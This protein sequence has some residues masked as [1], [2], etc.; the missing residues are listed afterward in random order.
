[1][2]GDW[3]KVEHATTRKAEVMKMARMLG[4]NRREMVGTLVDFFVWCDAN[5]VDG[6]VDGVVDADVD[7]VMMCP[8]LSAV[9]KEVGWLSFDADPPKMRM[10]NWDRHNGETAKKRALKNRAQSKWRAN[11]D[12]AQSTK[13]STRE[14]K[15]REDIKSKSIARKKP[16]LPLPPD[17]AISE[18]VKTWAAEKGFGLLDRHFEAFIGKVRAKGYTYVDWDEALMNCIRED[19]GKVN[20]RPAPEK[21]AAHS[22]A[23]LVE[24]GPRTEMPQHIGAQLAK[25]KVGG[26]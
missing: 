10:V 5:C 3:I 11:V 17:F 22:P 6:I 13:A 18:R 20:S 16:A 15:R 7:E 26:H 25:F 14:E 24:F 9:L 23:K 1:M 19:W 2:A 12:A 21:R 4:V 8:G